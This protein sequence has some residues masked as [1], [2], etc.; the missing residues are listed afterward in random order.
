M[1]EGVN[2]GNAQV[3]LS[4]KVKHLIVG[5]ILLGQDV[6]VSYQAYAYS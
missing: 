3:N 1:G 4:G 2:L 6:Y 5:Q